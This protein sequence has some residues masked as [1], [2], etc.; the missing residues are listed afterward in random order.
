MALQRIPLDK[1]S[2]EPE[3]TEDDD[4]LEEYDDEFDENNRREIIFDAQNNIGL[5][6]PFV[7]DV[8]DI[9]DMS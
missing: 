9:C 1:V 2:T 6:H 7:Y 5:V 3:R 8:F 4:D